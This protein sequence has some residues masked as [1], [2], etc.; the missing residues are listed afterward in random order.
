[1]NP[2]LQSLLGFFRRNPFAIGA[3][4]VAIL[5]WIANYFIWTQHQQL[6]AD[7]QEKQRS[8][9]DM[10]QSLTNHAR[11]STELAYVKDALARIDAHLVNEADLPENLGYFYQLE[12]RS[13]LRLESLSQLSSTPPPPG[14]PYK[15]VPFTLR[16]TGSYR[17]VLRFLR[18]IE[19]GPRLAKVQT[20]SLTQAATTTGHAGAPDIQLVTLDLTLELLAQP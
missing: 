3:S 9:E 14:Q 20:W 1:M 5:L 10:L 13:R 12:T 4:L 17:Q 16:T 6:A 19:T 18:E 8:G 2:F 11:I 15:T 7:H